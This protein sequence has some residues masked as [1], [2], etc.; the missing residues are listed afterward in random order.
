MWDTTDLEELARRSGFDG[1]DEMRQMLLR[2]R[3]RSP[4]ERAAYERWATGD[5]S[6]DGLLRLVDAVEG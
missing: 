4:R 6:K 3:L 2:V 1:L 5:G